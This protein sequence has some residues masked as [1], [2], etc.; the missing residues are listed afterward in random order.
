MLYRASGCAGGECGYIDINRKSTNPAG[1]GTQIYDNIAI[2][3]FGNGST[4]TST[5]N[6]FYKGATGSNFNGKP[7]Y[8]GGALPTSY[9]GFKLPP[10][11]PGKDM[12]FDG[13]DVGARIR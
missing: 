12:A 11:S 4:D 8:V 10:G 2:F 13:T 6:M 9:A 5:S 1:V 3:T 7:V